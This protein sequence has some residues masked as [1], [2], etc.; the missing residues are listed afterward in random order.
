MDDTHGKLEGARHEIAGSLAALAGEVEQLVDVRAW[1]QR[2]PLLFAGAAAL[3]GFLLAQKPRA[4]AAVMGRLVPAAA[5]AALR[6]MMERMGDQIGG[7]LANK[8]RPA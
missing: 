6:P 1:V 7:S 2:E 5:L 4:A 8:L 3:V